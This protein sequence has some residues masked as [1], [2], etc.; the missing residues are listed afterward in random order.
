MRF[1][2][3]V[4]GIALL[5]MPSVAFGEWRIEVTNKISHEVR[6]FNPPVDAI[7]SIPMPLG[8]WRC[9]TGPESTRGQHKLLSM[10]CLLGS[11][12]V[13]VSAANAEN[14]ESLVVIG[15]KNGRFMVITKW[16]SDH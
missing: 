9:A 5:T 13:S 7:F 1:V 12:E 3:F 14:G 15:S 11:A 8:G 6:T 4:V 10:T 2:S 16:K